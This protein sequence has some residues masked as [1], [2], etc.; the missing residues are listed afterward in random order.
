V[1]PQVPA[2]GQNSLT[3][4]EV[5]TW[6]TLDSI[7]NSRGGQ[8]APL[9]EFLRIWAQT[10]SDEDIESVS[11]PEVLS[12]L[13]SQDGIPWISPELIS[14]ESAEYL[15][16]LRER[17]RE[18]KLPCEVDVAPLVFSDPTKPQLF[19]G[20]TRA[21]L[22][23]LDGSL[24][25]KISINMS[26]LDRASLKADLERIGVHGGL[27]VYS[28]KYFQQKSAIDAFVHELH[29]VWAYSSGREYESFE[30]PAHL[31]ALQVFSTITPEKGPLYLKVIDKYLR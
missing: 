13:K 5:D 22:S 28:P 6:T 19:G 2:V 25:I 8:L 16:W 26:I 9:V 29:H 20:R 30:P 12:Q 14:S 10:T 27:G 11:S 17:I 23:P 21:S 7:A 18:N 24:G 4:H 15:I 1:N 3:A 31:G